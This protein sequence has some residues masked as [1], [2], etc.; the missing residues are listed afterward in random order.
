M[1]RALERQVRPGGGFLS[2]V[3]TQQSQ[4]EVCEVATHTAIYGL[5][6]AIHAFDAA[7]RGAE[8]DLELA[9]CVLDRLRPGAG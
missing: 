8:Q 6:G 5:V 1:T 4:I 7:S 2:R 9:E 3:F